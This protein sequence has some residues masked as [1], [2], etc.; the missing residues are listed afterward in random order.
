MFCIKTKMGI[1]KNFSTV[2]EMIRPIKKIEKA[3]DN[4]LFLGWIFTDLQKAFDTVDH[5]IFLHIRSQYGIRD[6]A[7]CWL[8]SYLSNRKYFVAINGFNSEL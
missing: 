3:A 7:N 4:N 5:D 6:T 8:S 1:Q 2:Q